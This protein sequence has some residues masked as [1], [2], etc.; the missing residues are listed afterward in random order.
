M[1][2]LKSE[3]GD[4]KESYSL[5]EIDNKLRIIKL[6]VELEEN[7]VKVNR[8]YV[9]NLQKK[10]SSLEKQIKCDLKLE[11]AI[12]QSIKDMN[13][14]QINS[15]DSSESINHQSRL[16]WEKFERIFNQAMT[17][18]EKLDKSK[19]IRERNQLKVLRWINKIDQHA[20]KYKTFKSPV[21][22]KEDF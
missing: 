18:D 3:A 20:K 8:I 14:S 13:E 15:K 19:A 4:H 2:S 6:N 1:K 7:E 12:D 9:D 21:N 17:L 22:N 5:E 16:F 11:E 10:V